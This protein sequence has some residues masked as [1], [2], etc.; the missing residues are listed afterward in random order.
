[1]LD[2]WDAGIL[3]GLLEKALRRRSL[4]KPASCVEIAS[5]PASIIHT[6]I[7]ETGPFSR[8]RAGRTLIPERPDRFLF[9]LLRRRRDRAQW[10]HIR[11]RL[12]PEH[13]LAIQLH[14]V[15]VFRLLG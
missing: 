4:M 9:R 6:Y 5:G 10:H 3:T 15:I 14:H 2:A 11:H 12:L 7:I 1:M 8:W 13:M